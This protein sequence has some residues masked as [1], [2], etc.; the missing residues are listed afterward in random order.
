MTSVWATFTQ[1]ATNRSHV[2]NTN[3]EI[4][5]ICQDYECKIASL[6]QEV[7]M[8]RSMMSSIT[9]EE[10]EEDDAFGKFTSR[11]V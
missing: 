2:H 7:E 6:Q 5:T 9:P 3:F 10:F 1:N 4:Y 11:M 8:S